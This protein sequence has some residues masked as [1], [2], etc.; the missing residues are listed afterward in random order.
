MTLQLF[1]GYADADTAIFEEFI[2]PARKA[3]PGFIT[4]FLGSRIRT[5]SIWKEARTLDRQLLSIPVPAD[6]HAEAIEWI[7]L[8]TAVRSA[9]DQFSFMELGAGFG[10]WTVAAAIASRL[11]GISK[12][13]LCAVE[14]DPQ[15]Y[16]LLRQHLIDNGLDPDQHTLLEAAVGVSAGV[17]EWPVLDES[18]STETWGLR[19]IQESGDYMGRQFQSTK[20]V[21]VIPMLDLVLKEPSWDLIH[22]DVQGEEV[23]ICRSCMAELSHRV[24][25]M[26]IATHSRKIEG[27]LLELLSQAGWLLE[28]EKPAKFTFV[29]NSTTLE[30]MTTLDGT[31]VWGNPRVIS[32]NS[33]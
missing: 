19:P 31:Q 7:G 17:A 32:P 25:R 29:P 20:Q 22:I 15:H 24:R 5:T 33:V 26:I 12:I 13:R 16:R 14:G 18:L 8:L 23:N 6:F 4:D 11:R 3:E 30:A 21:N 10:P 9:T 27:D 1:P 2:N 28:N